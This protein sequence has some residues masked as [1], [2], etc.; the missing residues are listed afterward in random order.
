LQQ[1]LQEVSRRRQ[2]GLPTL[3]GSLV[4]ERATNLFLRA[5]SAAELADLRDSRNS[6]SG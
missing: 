3:P 5:G 4:E 6:W 1:R 2:Q